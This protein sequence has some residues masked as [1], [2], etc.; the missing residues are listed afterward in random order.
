MLITSTF[1]D[2][3]AE[4]GHL[5]THVFPALEEWLRTK[6]LHLEWIDLRQGVATGSVQDEGAREAMVLKGCLDEVR[7]SRP[8]LIA[9]IG[10]RYGCVP[11]KERIEAAAHEAG[12]PGEVSGRSVTDLE[13]D[14]GVFHDEEQQR[15]SLFFLR[16]PL[17]YASMQPETA[18]EYSDAFATDADAPHRVDRLEKLKARLRAELPG[19]CFDYTATW[20]PKTG[21]VTGLDAWGRDVEKKVKAAIKEALAARPSSSADP[22]EDDAER[23]ALADFA[24]DRARDFVG[25]Q[26][27]LTD[28]EALLGSPAADGAPWGLFITGESGSGKSTAPIRW[29][30]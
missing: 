17:L 1:L 20:D 12:L 7:R 27:L 16:A 22:T 15:R 19:H 28:I 11:P 8:F 3:Q 4:R 30:D 23:T 13:I 6:R 14:F 2:M 9:L 10:D 24:E 25:R 18:A 21:R 5:R 29:S 26:A